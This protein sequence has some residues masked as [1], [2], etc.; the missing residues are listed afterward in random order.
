MKKTMRMTKL[1]RVENS[2]YVDFGR[3][4]QRKF[5]M[6]EGGKLNYNTYQSVLESFAQGVA[7]EI[8]FKNHYFTMPFGIGILRIQ[9]KEIYQ[10]IVDGKLEHNFRVNFIETKKLYE[11]DPEAKEKN[12]KIYYL[13]EHTDGKVYKFKWEKVTEAGKFN[14]WAGNRWAYY[15]RPLATVRET[16][17]KHLK[18]TTKRKE[19]FK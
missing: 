4:A 9:E 1:H 5:Y 6:S 10:A 13:N 12:K 15:L 8:V 14:I 2:R 7:N 11:K 17:V 3:G 16:L 18:D 19:Y